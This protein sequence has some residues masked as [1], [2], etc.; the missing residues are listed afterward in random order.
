M[1]DFCW[2][3]TKV[4]RVSVIEKIKKK[5]VVRSE[6][7]TKFKYVGLDIEQKED[8]IIISQDKYVE[9]LEAIPIPTLG[10]DVMSPD[11]ETSGRKVNGKLNWIATQTRPDL[12]FDVSEF[13]TFMKKGKL[14]C[15]KQAKKKYSQGKERKIKNMYS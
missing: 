4:F 6:E 14:E 13:S 1:D 8:K 3:G 9:T 10:D 2:G 5:F 11:D 12:S 15:I 7:S